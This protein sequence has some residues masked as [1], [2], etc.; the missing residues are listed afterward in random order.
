[1]RIVIFNEI[2][3]PRSSFEEDASESWG[4]R[5]VTDSVR[6]W[7]KSPLQDASGPINVGDLGRSAL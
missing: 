4:S 7:G 5:R 3:R 1:M 2:L 6:H